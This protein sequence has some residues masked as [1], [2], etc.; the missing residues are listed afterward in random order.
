[1]LWVGTGRSLLHK[2]C[3]CCMYLLWNSQCT[4]HHQ[5]VASHAQSLILESAAPRLRRNKDHASSVLAPTVLAPPESARSRLVNAPRSPPSP[6]IGAGEAFR[7]RWEKDCD[8]SLRTRAMS[9]AD[10]G[11]SAGAGVG[12][13]GAAFCAGVAAFFW[14][15]SLESSFW[16]VESIYALSAEKPCRF[17]SK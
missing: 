5:S 7:S 16:S 9:R 4:M 1:M 17:R 12:G 11:S 6:R 10:G 8:V 3:M 2:Y 14:T 15:L 13:A